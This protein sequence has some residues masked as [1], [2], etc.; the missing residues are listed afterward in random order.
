MLSSEIISRVLKIQTDYQNVLRSNF[1]ADRVER[2]KSM[3]ISNDSIKEPLIEHIGHLPIIATQLHPYL[4]RPDETDLG[5]TLLILS[6]HDIGETITGDINT[7]DKTVAEEQEEMEA[8]D[9][10]LNEEHKGL[11][12]EYENQTTNEGRF[13]ICVDKLAPKFHH[14]A[15]PESTKVLFKELNFG[16]EKM[17]RRQEHLFEWDSMLKNLFQEMILRFEKMEAKN[18]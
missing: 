11:L 7:F 10:L 15:H 18:G 1:T 5:K 14:L 13:A 4:D 9:T 6:I 8:A 12:D 3:D 17:V 2:F 16:P